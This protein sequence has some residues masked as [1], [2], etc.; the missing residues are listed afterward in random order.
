MLTIL[1]II[2]FEDGTC[3]VFYNRIYMLAPTF[4]EPFASE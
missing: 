3:I 4:H 1:R 2:S